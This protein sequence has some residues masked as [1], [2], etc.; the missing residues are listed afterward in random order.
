VEVIMHHHSNQMKIDW[1]R[2]MV[3]MTTIT[4]VMHTLAQ[5]LSSITI[6]SSTCMIICIFIRCT[7]EMKWMPWRGI[8]CPHS[9]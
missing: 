5:V 7:I 2:R 9:Q 4:V 1:W 6:I 3:H 8:S